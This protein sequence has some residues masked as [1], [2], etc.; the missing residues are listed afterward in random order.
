MDRKKCRET[1]A[2]FAVPKQALLLTAPIT[3]GFRGA[4][5]VVFLTLS[6]ADFQLRYA[7]VIEVHH[8]RHKGHA[9]ALSVRPQARQLFL[10]HK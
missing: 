3:L 8:N 1:V 2:L 10:G 9:L 6:D 5:V 7:F 4:F